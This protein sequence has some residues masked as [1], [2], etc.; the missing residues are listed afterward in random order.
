[1][2]P[3]PS[4]LPLEPRKVDPFSQAR[5]TISTPSGVRSEHFCTSETASCDTKF[6]ISIFFIFSCPNGGTELFTSSQAYLVEHRVT[7]SLCPDI[8]CG[9]AS[10][11][12]PRLQHW[13]H[14][15]SRQQFSCLY[16]VS[17]QWRMPANHRS[18]CRSCLAAGS[19]TASP[20][21]CC[22]ASCSP[23][24]D[25]DRCGIRPSVSAAL[26]R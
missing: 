15:V 26:P 12:S 14:S 25:A 7:V 8:I 21:A 1:M 22:G 11:H 13:R 17:R 20:A 10:R 19:R 2:P 16:R 5:E 23:R 18:A 3:F 4:P 6:S 9:T 24:S